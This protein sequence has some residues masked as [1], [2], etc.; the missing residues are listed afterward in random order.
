MIKTFHSTADIRMRALDAAVTWGNRTSFGGF[1][2]DYLAA[3]VRAFE[4]YI[5]TGEL[6]KGKIEMEGILYEAVPAQPATET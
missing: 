3:V 4:H 1:G 2:S 6:W 5:I